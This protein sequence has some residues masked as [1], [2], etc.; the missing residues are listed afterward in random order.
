MKLF[1]ALVHYPVLNRQGEKICSA[2]TNLDLH[3][4]S[5]TA[6]TYGAEGFFVVTPSKEQ[7]ALAKRVMAH[8]Q[9][10][11]GAE[12]NPDRKKAFSLVQLTDTIDETLARLPCEREKCLV[13]ATSA[14]KHRRCIEWEHMEKIVQEME[15]ECIVLLFGTASGLHDE[16]LLSCDGILCPIEGGTDY[17]HLSVRSAVA[18][19]LDRITRFRR[20]QKWTS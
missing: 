9:I 14:R 11:S 4:I 17:N 13:L 18:I 2:I 3:D 8:W 10:G 16:C 20:K 5:R 6:T 12:F 15:F 7:Q 19:T 1:I